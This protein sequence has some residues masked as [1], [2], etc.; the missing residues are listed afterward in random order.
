MI[1]RQKLTE[2]ELTTLVAMRSAWDLI[3]SMPGAPELA[4]MAGCTARE[5]R[6]AIES[7][8]DRGFVLILP[9]G[10]WAP[11]EGAASAI[12]APLSY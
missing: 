9:D 8:V 6:A 3:G 10:G 5:C 1:E 4:R 7:L 12:N 11:K 2:T